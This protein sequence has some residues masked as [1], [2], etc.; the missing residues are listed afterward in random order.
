MKLNVTVLVLLTL[1]LILGCKKAETTENE[2]KNETVYGDSL[3]IYFQE[4]E[5][6]LIEQ[7]TVNHE[8][9]KTDNDFYI[10]Y[11]NANTLK[12]TLSKTL[13]ANA[14]EQKEKGITNIASLDWFKKVAKGL[15]V[16]TVYQ[17]TTYEV[18][19]DY[20]DF[21]DHAIQTTGQR[22]DKFIKLLELCYNSH[23]HFTKW[24]QPK[25]EFLGCNLLG[26]G[27]YKNIFTLIDE[28][29]NE[30]NLFEKEIFDLQKHLL[31]DLYYKPYFC[32]SKESVIKEI[33]DILNHTQ[34]L[35]ED[36]KEILKD[37]VK[38]IKNNEIDIAQFDCQKIDCQYPY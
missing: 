1:V 25:T 24:E 3:D 32:G 37:Y 5:Q 26:N 27:M 17:G 6:K 14:L 33:S 16:G 11:R 15:E 4:F 38:K 21:H 35:S 10:F 18:F 28:T 20:Q 30:S 9:L 29:L 8:N 31:R 22:D 7:Y 13:K 2:Q 34:H 12:K 36:R 19:F 23:S